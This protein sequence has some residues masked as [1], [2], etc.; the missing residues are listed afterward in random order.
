MAGYVV[1]RNQGELHERAV[2][3]GRFLP[4]IADLPP[5]EVLRS[6]RR[7]QFVG[8]PAELV[9]QMRPFV[10]AGVSLFTLQHFLYD[11]ADALELLASEVMPELQAM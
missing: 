7:R 8:T 6:L 3:F 2:R 9:A 5:D 11:D 10:D 1:G 4:G